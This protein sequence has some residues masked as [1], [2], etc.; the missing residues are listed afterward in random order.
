MCVKFEQVCVQFSVLEDEGLV[1]GHDVHSCQLMPLSCHHQLGY[2]SIPCSRIGRTY[3]AKAHVIAVRTVA[4]IELSEES[5]GGAASSS[6]QPAAP[7]GAAP[8]SP[9]APAEEEVPIQQTEM[10]Y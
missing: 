10:S 9:T 2:S 5:T 1:I 6:S 4:P 8:A 3:D 7:V